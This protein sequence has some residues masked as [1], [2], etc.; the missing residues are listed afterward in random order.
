MT[1]SFFFSLI[2]SLLR[3]IIGITF[4]TLFERKILAYIQLRK[5]PNK[6]GF[7][8]LPQPIADAIKLF[9]KEH[10]QPFKINITPFIISPIIALTLSSII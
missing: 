9:T 10:T 3:A 6:V 8:G 5:G 2:V 4:F 1:I 7:I